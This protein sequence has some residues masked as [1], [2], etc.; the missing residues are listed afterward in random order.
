MRPQ[1][2]ATSGFHPLTEKG[3]EALRSAVT[4][5]RSHYCQWLSARA[6]PTSLLLWFRVLVIR[7]EGVGSS[8]VRDDYRATHRSAVM[9][10]AGRCT[11]P[12][13]GL[14]KRERLSSGAWVF[15]LAAWGP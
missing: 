8:T 7:R 13:P 2:L 9:D 6:K 14:P 4:C 15:R 3:A 11:P 10:P 1:P 12:Y 5:V